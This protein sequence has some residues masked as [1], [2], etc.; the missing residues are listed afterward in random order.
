MLRVE[1]TRAPKKLI[2]PFY[3]YTTY[4]QMSSHSSCSQRMPTHVRWGQGRFQ[5]Q[6][7]GHLQMHGH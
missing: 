5:A 3:F 4:K 6:L 7:A 2:D 1:K